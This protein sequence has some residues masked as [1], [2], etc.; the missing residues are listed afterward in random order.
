M[1]RGE[2]DF[3]YEVGPEAREFLAVERPSNVFPF[4]RSYV[5]RCHPQLKRADFRI[6]E[7]AG[8]EPRRRYS[9]TLC[10]RRSEGTGSPQLVRHGLNTGH[11]T[12][13]RP[14]LFVR[15]VAQPRLLDAGNSAGR[16]CPKDVA[17]RAR[18]QFIV[19][20]SRKISRCGSGWPA[21]GSARPRA[22]RRRHATRSG[23]RERVQPPHRRATSMPS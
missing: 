9:Q 22:D 2:V 11:L 23:V 5:Y 3:L 8:A 13:T 21:D 20:H 17:D 15:S 18:F 16:R 14:G 19:P 12:R 6:R 7:F 4:L 10:S 1:M